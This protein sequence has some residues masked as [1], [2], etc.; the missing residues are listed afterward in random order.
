MYLPL[1]IFAHI[2]PID[3]YEPFS[4]PFPL[5]TVL[6]NFQLTFE[7]ECSFELECFVKTKSLGDSPLWI[8]LNEAGVGAAT[9]EPWLSQ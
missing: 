4:L 5:Q 2:V 1:W 6:L 7:L 8:R 9:R 3:I